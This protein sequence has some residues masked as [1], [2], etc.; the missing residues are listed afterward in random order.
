MKTSGDDRFEESERPVEYEN[1]DQQEIA[2]MD[3]KD[4]RPVR[5]NFNREAIYSGNN[6]RKCNQRKRPSDT[7]KEGKIRC[8][9]HKREMCCECFET[10]ADEKGHACNAMV[11]NVLELRCGFKLPLVADACRVTNRDNMPVS[12][13]Y[14]E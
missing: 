1:D 3:V 9:A 7:E 13:G 4:V 10:P 5:N 2:A 14:L 8:R 12:D 6:Q 11:T